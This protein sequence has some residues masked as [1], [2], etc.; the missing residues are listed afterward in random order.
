M[1]V[2]SSNRK[3]KSSPIPTQ[4]LNEPPGES[5]PPHTNNTDRDRDTD[6]GERS[7]TGKSLLWPPGSPLNESSAQ[8]HQRSAEDQLNQKRRS[9]GPLWRRVH[10]WF[11]KN[12]FTPTWLPKK[13]WNH[14]IIGYAAAVVLQIA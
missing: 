1:L 2:K 9:R 7:T 13:K 8:V 5:A 10:R 6:T 11:Q 12:T 3:N 14:P 4:E